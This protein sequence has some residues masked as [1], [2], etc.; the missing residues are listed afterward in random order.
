MV[1][2]GY[3]FAVAPFVLEYVFVGILWS[4]GLASE[5][6]SGTGAPLLRGPPECR[7]V[8]TKP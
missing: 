2:M 1:F 6:L 5:G 7:E 4:R 3:L 8:Y